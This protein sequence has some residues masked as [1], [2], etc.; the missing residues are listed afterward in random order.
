MENGG[1][2]KERKENGSSGGKVRRLWNRIHV[3]SSQ[4]TISL[5]PHSARSLFIQEKKFYL[6]TNNYWID[7]LNRKGHRTQLHPQPVISPYHLEYY[8]PIL[9][10]CGY[11][12]TLPAHYLC[13]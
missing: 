2:E 8:P 13:I 5:T 10:I 12:D 1:R 9:G 11:T 3:G 7:L 6:Q 4:A